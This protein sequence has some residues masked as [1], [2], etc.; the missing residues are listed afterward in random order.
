MLR[1]YLLVALLSS[2]LLF[3]VNIPASEQHLKP[4]TVC[5][6]LKNRKLHN[7]EVVAVIGLWSATDEGFWIFDECE[8]KIRTGDY[9]WPDDISLEY[10]PSAPSAFKGEMPLDMAVAGEKIEEMKGRIKSRPDK[11]QWAVV[12]G[13]FEAREELQTVVASDGK[14]VRRVGFGHLGGSPAQ[15]V[16]K[17]KDIKFILEKLARRSDQSQPDNGMHPTPRNRA[18]HRR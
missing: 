3:A 4:I 16:Y 12:Y 5:E 10:D 2:P 14:T 15:V 6:A 7:G 1:N 13:R 9:V 8:Q 11:V 18:S 17:D